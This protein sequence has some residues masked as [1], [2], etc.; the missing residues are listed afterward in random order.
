M[1][2]Q[3]ET[4]KLFQA[5]R[6]FVAI[7]IQKLATERGVHAETA[8][9]GVA[10]MAGTFLFRS[11]GFTL[12]DLKPGQPTLSEQANERGPRLVDIT[13]TLLKSAGINIELNDNDQ[14]G[15]EPQFSFLDSQRLL[16]PAFNAVRESSGLT[17]VQGADAAAVAT[18]LLIQQTAAVLDPSVAF[19]IAVYG[20]IEGSKTAPD[21]AA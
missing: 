5:A 20:F 10:R 1:S 8:V 2:E 17:L 4:E 6:A 18:A 14:S 19:S 15:H 12:P 7:A 3:I 21:P 13:T 9:A 16:E 11:F